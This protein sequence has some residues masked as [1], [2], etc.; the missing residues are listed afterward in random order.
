MK[1]FFIGL[2][3]GLGGLALIGMMAILVFAMDRLMRAVGL[4]GP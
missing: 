2:G 1:R 4:I 3:A